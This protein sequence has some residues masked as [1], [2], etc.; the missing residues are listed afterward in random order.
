MAKITVEEYNKLKKAGKLQTVTGGDGSGT[1]ANVSNSAPTKAQI[2]AAERESIR[3]E[4]ERLQAAT[5]A[6]NQREAAWNKQIHD[7][8]NV[9]RI[10]RVIFWV[11]CLP[12][13]VLYMCS[14]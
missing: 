3:L 8:N 9:L 13:A 10:G 12:L 1:D 6:A 5:K 11:I 2:R 7:G 4:R 14:G